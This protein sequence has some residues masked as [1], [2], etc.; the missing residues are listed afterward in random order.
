MQVL[1][2]GGSEPSYSP[3]PRIVCLLVGVGSV[4]PLRSIEYRDLRRFGLPGRRRWW[5]LR[6]RFH[7]D[8]EAP[9]CIIELVD[10][11]ALDAIEP[12]SRPRNRRAQTGS[13]RGSHAADAANVTTRA[14]MQ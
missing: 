11:A 3:I 9:D 7:P 5:A 4:L 10:T 2:G 8:P 12:R 1:P 13:R 14:R 6:G